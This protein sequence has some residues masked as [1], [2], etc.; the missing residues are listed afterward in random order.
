MSKYKFRAD[1]ATINSD[2]GAY[3]L[4][5]ELEMDTPQLKDAFLTIF[6]DA[7]VAELN[8]WLSDLGYT[9]EEIKEEA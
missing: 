9:L 8:S 4:N 3:S 2:R 5:V 6:D 1:E 7:P